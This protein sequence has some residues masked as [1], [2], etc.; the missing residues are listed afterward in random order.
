[1]IDGES[2]KT[3]RTLSAVLHPRG[4]ALTRSG[5]LYVAN[6]DGATLDVFHGES[7][8]H[9][10]RLA[11]CRIPRH[12]A[13]SPDDKTLYISCYHDSELHADNAHTVSQQHGMNTR[14]PFAPST[15]QE[16]HQHCLRL[17]VGGVGGGDGLKALLPRQLDEPFVAQ[18]AAGMFE[19][20]LVRGGVF[21]DI[22]AACK[23]Q[24]VVLL[25]ELGHKPLI[26]V[27]VDPAKPMVEVGD[28][29]D[30]SQLR[31]QREQHAHQRHRIC[32]ARDGNDNA[33]TR[34][35]QAAFANCREHLVAHGLIVKQAAGAWSASRQLGTASW[36]IFCCRNRRSGALPAKVRA[37]R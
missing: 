20:Q 35:Q 6:F 33:V 23:E 24:Q 2:G 14:E 12:L 37:W 32:T 31:A 29:Q 19:A 22:G 13:L 21:A 4:I 11:V 16:L 15:A 9:S 36:P 26:S 10:Y 27:G 8:A 28:S 3:S 34:A 25:G 30:D 17:I 5:I 7:F 18:F 1:M